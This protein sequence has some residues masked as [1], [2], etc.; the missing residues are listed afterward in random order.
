M[1]TQ[2]VWSLNYRYLCT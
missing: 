1:L 2:D